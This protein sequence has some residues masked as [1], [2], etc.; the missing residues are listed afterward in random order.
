MGR[1]VGGN[2]L[3]ERE[4]DVKITLYWIRVVDTSLIPGILFRELP[5]KL[6]RRCSAH[7]GVSLCSFL[8]LGDCQEEAAPAISTWWR[9]LTCGTLM[10][11]SP[12]AGGV[13]SMDGW[14]RHCACAD[15]CSHRPGAYAGSPLTPTV[16]LP[17]PGT[18]PDPSSYS[19]Q[20]VGSL[21]LSLGFRSLI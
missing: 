12:G 1:Y 15:L 9:E 4:K 21:C 3:Q 19:F 11:A 7:V 8:W 17:R 16:A 10:Q 13:T 5:W 20:A 2:G 6:N 14:G 18:G